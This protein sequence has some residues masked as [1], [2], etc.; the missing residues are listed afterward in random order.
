VQ[1]L[2]VG[3]SQRTEL[4]SG[5]RLQLAVVAQSP[6]DQS[7][8][9]D[10][11]VLPPVE[12]EAAPGYAAHAW[13]AVLRQE[14]EVLGRLRNLRDAL[15]IGGTESSR[16]LF[17]CSLAD[18][19]GVGLLL[20]VAN[21][22]RRMAFTD[23]WSDL[24]E[25]RAILL[26]PAH[27]SL[28]ERAQAAA[29]LRE[30]RQAEACRWPPARALGLQGDPGEGQTPLF[31]RGCF[32]VEPSRESGA[33]CPAATVGQQ[34]RLVAEWLTY[35]LSPQIQ[36]ELRQHRLDSPR[37]RALSTQT[38]PDGSDDVRSP[39][40][41]PP[42]FCSLGLTDYIV[43]VTDVT[44]HCARRLAREVVKTTLLPDVG[45]RGIAHA[46]AFLDRS[47]L[48]VPDLTADLAAMQ[49]ER[50]M[51]RPLSEYP[52]MSW[53]EEGDVS[54]AW[55]FRDRWERHELPVYS[56]DLALKAEGRVAD[57]GEE[58]RKESLNLASSEPV[59]VFARVL[60]FLEETRRKLLASSTETCQESTRVQ[61]A[62]TRLFMVL[63][64]RKTFALW[65]ERLIAVFMR[66]AKCSLI[67]SVVLWMLTEI[68]KR[69]LASSRLQAVLGVLQWIGVDLS[70]RL[71]TVVWE[72][73]AV[74]FAFF[75]AWLSCREMVRNH[76]AQILEYLTHVRRHHLLEAVSA[77]LRG[78]RSKASGVEMH[79]DAL[80]TETEAMVAAE[81][82]SLGAAITPHNLADG[83]QFLHFPGRHSLA[84]RL[85]VEQ[86]YARGTGVVS[87][88]D[89]A[90]SP[91]EPVSTPAQTLQDLARV[92]FTEAWYRQ[93][94]ADR[95]A[96]LLA[97]CRKLF[98]DS[99]LPDA[100]SLLVRRILDSGRL[101]KSETVTAVGE[102]LSLRFIPR[103][104]PLSSHVQTAEKPH[105]VIG[106]CDPGDSRLAEA[107]EKLLLQRGQLFVVQTG[108]R[109]RIVGLSFRY[110]LR[111]ED[112][113]L[114]TEC[115]TAYARAEDSN[116]FHTRLVFSGRTTPSA[117]PRPSWAE[118]ARTEAPEDYRSAGKEADDGGSGPAASRPPVGPAAA[119]PP[120]ADDDTWTD[121]WA[122]MPEAG[123]PSG[124]GGPDFGST[125]GGTGAVAVAA[126]YRF[127]GLEP[128]ASPEKV[129]D[130]YWDAYSLYN[131]DTGSQKDS[132]KMAEFNLAYDR[133]K[134]SW[135][136]AA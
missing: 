84:T 108:L 11:A 117:A 100:E 2:A 66:A 59:G 128:D 55:G 74:A 31:G 104:Q 115:E 43:P 27:P 134:A 67:G 10:P 71:T 127:L 5:E 15:G 62:A 45:E 105:Q 46:A 70:G 93:S 136:V 75:L 23:G 54:K 114:F 50:P 94:V 86:L 113:R 19:Q 6:N 79:I 1:F 68:L 112:L 91:D 133:I 48:S 13:L 40:P 129:D 88:I 131:P 135:R 57:G 56:Y 53:K 21:L 9:I 130:A 7:D 58:L 126:S 101:P 82:P 52:E 20:P 118:G 89:L 4:V 32:L 42:A 102:E 111:L 90:Q 22:V 60:S 37:P 3:F 109:S 81:A 16:Y 121:Q 87:P 14:D 83:T 95:E 132:D 12:T 123:T 125:P 35:V 96:A 33:D 39:E 76:V 65:C 36:G 8:G 122:T 44:E 80:R 124:A 18:P 28:E 85:A 51:T 120:S 38:Q 98:L 77:A 78:I 64:R 41:A 25:T 116:L 63:A 97:H 47:K 103:M 26:L 17:T 69:L 24:L 119:P 29:A 30:I 99:G 34:N 73:L 107:I 110:D 92:V 72:S 49:T 106:L 61:A